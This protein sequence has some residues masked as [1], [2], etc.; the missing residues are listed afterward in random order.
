MTSFAKLTTAAVVGAVI[1]TELAHRAERDAAGPVVVG[2][3]HLAYEEH[4]GAGDAA[5]KTPLVFVHGWPDDPRIFTPLCE[6]LSARHGYRCVNV[7]L[8]AYGL[9][10]DWTGVAER[11][12]G[13]AR[14]WGFS[15]DEA[16]ELL[17]ATIVHSCGAR[18]RVTL[19]VHDWGCV[20][21]YELKRRHPDLVARLVSADVG[22]PIELRPAFSAF[23][24][25]YQTL[26]NLAWLLPAP[27]GN[28]IN[29]VV[30]LLGRRCAAAGSGAPTTQRN[31]P[32]RAMFRQALTHPV[33][34]AESVLTFKPVDTP[35]LYVYG[36][37]KPAIAQ[38]HD[39]T[40]LAR[41]RASSPLSRV[42]AL[43]GHHWFVVSHFE[44]YAGEVLK[45]LSET[46]AQ[47]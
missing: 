45:F 13:G 8:P 41:V 30:A 11:L 23:F 1:A 28:L 18:A 35:W 46:E 19:V 24:L 32:Y 10:D 22:L 20:F 47:Q 39:A 34:T 27:L 26:L 25:G 29:A 37:D 9:P 4:A 42:V 44:Q 17:R 7:S 33:A 16:L 36:R 3:H 40:F 31:W 12:P 6:R 38:F 21:G 15:M 2:T 14:R 43:P 5:A